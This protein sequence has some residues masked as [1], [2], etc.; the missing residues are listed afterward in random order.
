VH[1]GV[2][3]DNEQVFSCVPGHLQQLIDMECKW[4]CLIIVVRDLINNA[5]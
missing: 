3:E 5:F 4:W 1:A 2:V